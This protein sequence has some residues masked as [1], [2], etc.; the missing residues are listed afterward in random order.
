MNVDFTPTE[1][2]HY[3]GYDIIVVTTPQ[4]KNPNATYAWGVYKPESESANPEIAGGAE[5][6]DAAMF[7]ATLMAHVMRHAEDTK[8][9]D[10]K[11]RPRQHSCHLPRRRKDYPDTRPPPSPSNSE[12]LSPDSRLAGTNAAGAEYRAKPPTSLRP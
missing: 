6:I 8:N 1:T 5:S 11:G 9:V 7:C 3:A 4:G 12:R 10:D 2:A